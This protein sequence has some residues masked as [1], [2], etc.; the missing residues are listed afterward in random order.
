MNKIYWVA[1]GWL[2]VGIPISESEHMIVLKPAA[3]LE[4]P[5]VAF[6]LVLATPGARKKVAEI[7]PIP[8][9]LEIR[10]HAILWSAEAPELVDAAALNALEKSK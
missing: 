2:F 10:K 3:W 7:H 9:P 5:G 1:P 6:P 8:G 4:N